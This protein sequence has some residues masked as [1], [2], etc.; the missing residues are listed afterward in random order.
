[1][2]ELEYST[3]TH[4]STFFRIKIEGVGVSIAGI[5]FGGVSIGIDITVCV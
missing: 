4:L 2:F 5:A 3:P 1:M